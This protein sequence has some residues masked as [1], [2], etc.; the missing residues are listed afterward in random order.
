MKI[1]FFIC[2]SGNG[3]ATRFLAIFE[4][5]IKL[6]KIEKI[7][8]FC[9]S[10]YDFIKNEI[11]KINKNNIK[12]KY[13]KKETIFSWFPDINGCPSV[14]KIKSHY[15]SNF[16]KKINSLVEE[17]SNL[18][19]D[20]DLVIND[21]IPYA[22]LIAKK[23]NVKSFS[24]FHFQWSWFLN[25]CY[26]SLVNQDVLKGI[27]KLEELSDYN[28]CSIFTPSEIKN[29]LKNIK[30]INP[31]IRDDV[32]QIK[33]SPDKNN[34]FTITII[35]SGA[36]HSS[37]K[38]SSIIENPYF[39]EIRKKENLILNVF[40]AIDYESN[41]LHK[42]KFYKNCLRENYLQILNDSHLIIARPGFNLL[43][44]LI[45]LNKSAL[46]FCENGN[47]EMVDI[48]YQLAKKGINNVL[49]EEPKEQFNMI[50]KLVKGESK[51]VMINKLAL[52]FNG[53]FEIVKA[54]F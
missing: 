29:N 21:G 50:Y 45:Y 49:P 37:K 27:K 52:K 54:I 43:T 8:L 22:N 16:F 51:Q 31:I 24:I 12:I 53:A 38:I 1:A 10:N 48:I 44:E 41:N 36:N 2:D 23:I 47:P 9:G 5:L 40:S 3:H 25:K 26:F 32:T 4:Q 15:N 18:I 33:K 11:D 19:R 28:F 42:V 13:Y 20:V 14:E 46:F 17:E 7:Y 34:I 30:I 35:D 6:N 39:L